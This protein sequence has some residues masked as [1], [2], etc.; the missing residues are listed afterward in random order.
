[1]EEKGLMKEQIY[2]SAWEAEKNLER[3]EGKENQFDLDEPE[4]ANYE[5]FLKE[6]EL[7]RKMFQQQLKADE[8][9]DFNDA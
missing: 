9:I 8:D 5:Q 7:K 4:D 1:M 3:G 6:E 2:N